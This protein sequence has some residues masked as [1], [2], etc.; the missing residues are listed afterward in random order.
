MI[1]LLHVLPGSIAQGL[2]WGILAISVFLTFKV[3]DYA[4][5]TVDGSFCTG[6][7]TTVMLML[8]GHNVYL[9]LLCGTIAGMLA[10]Y[11]TGLLHTMLKIP[12]ILSGIL[13]QLGLYSVN[14]AIM[15]KS[16]QAISVDQ[17][18]LIVSLRFINYSIIMSLIVVAVI[19][20]LLYLF[21]GSEIGSAIRAT[22]CNQNMARAQGINTGRCIRIG[23]VVSNGLTAF[24]GGM[25]AQYQGNADVNAGRGA[26]VI[27]LAAVIIGEVIFGTRH[28]FALRMA[29]SVCGAIIY[30][31]VIAVVL[32]LGLPSTYLKLL[33][34]VLVAI[35]LGIPAIQSYFGIKSKQ[36]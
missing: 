24:A 34:A 10:G 22:G 19:I 16:N 8:S 14:L 7:A 6:G 27:G 11:V 23:L 32:Q 1:S 3:L 31:I 21:F 28:N 9:A 5:M 15:G 2:I 26:I 4:D 30:Y 13:T 35:F 29:F 36:A 18:A 17:Y 33:S 12:P 25:Y 20:V